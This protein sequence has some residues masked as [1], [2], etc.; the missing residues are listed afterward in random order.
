MFSTCF[1]MGA[2][3]VIIISDS[4][5]EINISNKI[6][7]LKDLKAGITL[8]D[9]LS[10]QYEKQFVKNTTSSFGFGNLKATIWHTF[11]ITN[12]D[13]SH[14][15][16]LLVVDN[17][18]L[19]SLTLFTK[20]KEGIYQSERSGRLIPY[21]DRKYKYN[22]FAFDLP[23]SS[24]DT[25]VYYLKVSSYLLNYPIQVIRYDRFAELQMSRSIIMGVL[26]GFLLMIVLYNLFIYYTERDK[27]YLFYIAYVFITIIKITDMKGYMDVIYQ[28]PLSFMRSQTPGITPFLGVAMILFTINILDFRKNL[29]GAIKWVII[30]FV[31]MMLSALFFDII[32]LKLYSSVINQVGTISLTF[33]LYICA[34]KIYRKGYRPARYF[35]IAVSAFFLSI[36]IYTLCLFG[37]IPLNSITDNLIEIGS[38]MEMLLFSLALADKIREYKRAKNQAEKNLLKTLQ[39]NEE[40]ILNQ[41]KILEIKVKERTKDLNDEKEKSDNLLLNILPTEIA[42]ELKKNGQS[43][44]RMY[45]YTSVLFTDFVNFT[46]VSEKFSPTELVKEINYCF[47][48]FDNI[49]GRIGLEKIKTIGD[50]YLAVCGLPIADPDHAIKTI[51]AALEILQF[52]E[53]HHKQGGAFKIRIGIHS[54]PL[55]AGI[56]GVKK[57][58]YDIWG[59][60]VNTAARMEQNSESG[61]INISGVTYEI[62]KDKVVCIHR[63]KIAA[64]NKGEVDMYFVQGLKDVS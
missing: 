50:A 59:D 55:V 20:S 52:V 63:G 42:E 19:D 45:D 22:T 32:D 23:M 24:V 64:K 39:E 8:D 10:G 58:A 15:K 44:A 28:G 37:V 35:I 16:W 5:D 17:H 40:L 25:Q 43:Q 53:D 14:S 62:V 33:F 18:H 3:D 1:C 13:G 2:E 47:T 21:G 11:K 49:V 41:N 12:V 9:I 27:N 31:P 29:P 7:Y 51:Q 60:T 48:A 30:L 46:G 4:T 57:F 36:C 56:I 6:Y 61:K 34:I 38:G 26:I 54:G